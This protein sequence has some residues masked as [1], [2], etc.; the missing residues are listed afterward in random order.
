MFGSRR[1]IP[2]WRAKRRLV[3]VE[4]ALASTRHA[5]RKDET[6]SADDVAARR[7]RSRL[8]AEARKKARFAEG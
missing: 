6:V 3:N 1:S 5:D 2:F 4:R 8:A 7:A